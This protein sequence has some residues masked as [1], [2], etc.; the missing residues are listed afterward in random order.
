MRTGQPLG[1]PLR[2]CRGGNGKGAESDGLLAD[3]TNAFKFQDKWKLSQLQMIFQWRTYNHK[4][5]DSQMDFFG[6][7]IPNPHEN[8]FPWSEL[9][10][11]LERNC[12]KVDIIL[13]YKHW[14]PLNG[15]QR[16]VLSFC[17]IVSWELRVDS[18]LVWSGYVLSIEYDW[19]WS[20]WEFVFP[21]GVG[22]SLV[23]RTLV[24]VQS[25]LLYSR[26]APLAPLAGAALTNSDHWPG[27]AG[28]QGS[29]NRQLVSGQSGGQQTNNQPGCSFSSH[30][31][32][33]HQSQA[34]REMMHKLHCAV[35]ATQQPIKTAAC[36]LLIIIFTA[37]DV[38][39]H[40]SHITSCWPAGWHLYSAVDTVDTSG[41]SGH[42]EWPL[43][44]QPH[45]SDQDCLSL[46]AD[47]P[48]LHCMINIISDIDNLQTILNL[49]QSA[50]SNLI[51]LQ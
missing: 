8:R 43:S 32:H 21:P 29:A 20:V 48:T 16:R 41:H 34:E 30:S 7:C 11:M 18:I 50:N 33:H 10:L 36:F 47:S 17:L 5:S 31:P 6:K 22:L 15:P 28:R 12:K 37:W 45:L 35:S 4:Y 13:L 46:Q 42:S 9:N 3:L 24:S 27:L 2:E 40:G 19:L 44:V 14:Q 1:P 38:A 23:V 51:A 25:V 39:G 49:I 26:R